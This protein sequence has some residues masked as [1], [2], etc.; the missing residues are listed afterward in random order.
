MRTGVLFFAL[1]VSVLA[2]TAGQSAAALEEQAEHLFE[3]QRWTDAATTAEAAVHA[4][5]SRVN[6]HVILGLIATRQG[7][8]ADA[9]RHFEKAAALRP[10]DARIMG[11]LASAYFQQGRMAEAEPLFRRVVAV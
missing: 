4:D 3:D 1:A 5:P 11:Y 8:A 9:S 7:K 6:A 10:K 2:Q